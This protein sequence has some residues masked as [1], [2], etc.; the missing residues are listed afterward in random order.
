MLWSRVASLAASSVYIIKASETLRAD[1]S[2]AKKYQYFRG[3]QFLRYNAFIMVTCM[4]CQNF[5]FF[6]TRKT[7]IC[8][9]IKRIFS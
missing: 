7:Q 3:G 9:K 5:L 1:I 8:I 6:E 4:R 2:A